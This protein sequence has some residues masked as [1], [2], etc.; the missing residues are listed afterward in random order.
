MLKT[1]G[2]P[3]LRTG[4]ADRVLGVPKMSGCEDLGR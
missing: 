3:L 1:S 4:S 2:Y